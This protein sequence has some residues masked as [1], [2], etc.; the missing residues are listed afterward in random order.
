VLMS[1]LLAASA[2]QSPAQNTVIKVVQ[3]LNFKLT[4]YYQQSSTENPN[5]IFKHAGKISVT[6][7]DIINLLEPEVNIIFSSNAKLMLLSDVPVDQTPQ[8][9]VRDKF[10]GEWF[11][12][13]VTQHFSAEV[14]ASIEDGK[15][16]KNPIKASGKSYDVVVFEMGLY[17]AQFR[18]QGFGKTKIQTAKHE[19]ESAAIVHTGKID[20]SGHGAY[21]VNILSGVVPVVLEGTV[22]ILGNEVKS[23]EE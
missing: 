16:N 22:Q 3:E 19:G 6:N 5:A 18:I 21:A 23:L 20:A 4:G 12:T 13:D 1:A 2:A 17:Q 7:K 10:Q 9:V 15:V 11:D 8:V 14:L